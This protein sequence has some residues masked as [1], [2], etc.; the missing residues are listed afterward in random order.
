[1]LAVKGDGGW[2]SR[3]EVM[4]VHTWWVCDQALSPKAVWPRATGLTYSESRYL[5][6][7]NGGDKHSL[8]AR[9]SGQSETVS[10]KTVICAIKV[11]CL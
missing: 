5:H 7:L 4:A 6:L 8:V 11:P 1:M 9:L 3:A 10:S 2:P